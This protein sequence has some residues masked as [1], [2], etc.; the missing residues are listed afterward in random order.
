MQWQIAGFVAELFQGP[1]TACVLLDV[2]QER[3]RWRRPQLL[4]LPSGLLRRLHPLHERPRRFPDPPLRSD[5]AP[6]APSA[7]SA[8]NLLS[9]GGPCRSHWV[10]PACLSVPRRRP[11]GGEAGVDAQKSRDGKTV[12][13]LDS[14][15]R[16]VVRSHRQH[17][18]VHDWSN[19]NIK[20]TLTFSPAACAPHSGKWAASSPAASASTHRPASSI[21]GRA[22]TTP[23]GRVPDSGSRLLQGDSATQS[24]RGT[25]DVKVR[26][27]HSPLAHNSDQ[28]PPLWIAPSL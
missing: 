28:F 14:P 25:V 5:P 11:E 15:R 4:H 22:A 21:S 26:H 19:L 13:R 1:K 7:G 24:A 20:D 12:R 9:A 8:R 18:H 2:H 10:G 23:L 27:P 3:H 6:S 17:C 16:M